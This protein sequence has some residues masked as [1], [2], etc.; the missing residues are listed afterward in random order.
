MENIINTLFGEGLFSNIYFVDTNPA[1]VKTTEIKKVDSEIQKIENTATFNMD[2]YQMDTSGL[3]SLNIRSHIKKSFFDLLEK[4]SDQKEIKYFDRGFIKNLFYPKNPNEIFD[5]I[6][7]Q[8]WIITSDNIIAEL[9]DAAEIKY[10][11]CYADIRLVGKIE[12]T[13]VYKSNHLTNEIYIGTFDCV[14]PVFNRNIITDDLKNQ[15]IEYL[16][17]INRQ[18]TKITVY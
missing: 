1:I 11:L 7:G 17:N 4:N 3:I 12:N 15:N 9:T 18:I 16:F 2:S 13:L 14:T 10:M 6:K 5:L 8:N